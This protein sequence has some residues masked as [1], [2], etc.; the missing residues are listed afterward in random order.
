[1][2]RKII[3]LKGN[4]VYRYLYFITVKRLVI[5]IILKLIYYSLGSEAGSVDLNSGSIVM[6]HVILDK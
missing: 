4:S 2:L 5:M 3:Y 6:E 1:M